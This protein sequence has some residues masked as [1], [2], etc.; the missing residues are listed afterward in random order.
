MWERLIIMNTKVAAKKWHVNERSV[1]RY[2]A[3]GKVTKCEKVNNQWVI[4]DE[5]RC[6]LSF[7]NTASINQKNQMAYIIKAINER[8]TI[9]PIALGCD[10][11][12]L[13]A[14][15]EMFV[16]H[17]LI[18]KIPKIEYEDR[19]RN[20]IITPEA[21]M[22]CDDRKTIKAIGK[23]IYDTVQQ[24][25]IAGAATAVAAAMNHTH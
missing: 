9:T 7:R 8:K 2:C 18:Y 13:D 22:I 1:T 4:D 25:I 20:Y 23:W 10:E 17:R 24:A 5:A 3:S 11:E 19:F 21:R 14:F 6:P 15:F 16:L 12:E